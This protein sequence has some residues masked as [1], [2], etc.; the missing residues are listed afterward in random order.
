VDVGGKSEKRKG[1][2]EGG[3]AVREIRIFGNSF[4]RKMEGGE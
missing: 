3:R 2:G 4:N 1:K